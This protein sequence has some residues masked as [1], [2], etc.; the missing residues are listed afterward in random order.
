MTTGFSNITISMRGDDHE[1]LALTVHTGRIIDGEAILDSEQVAQ[2][3][4]LWTN[5]TGDFL[6][7]WTWGNTNDESDLVFA[8]TGPDGI[9]I[10]FWSTIGP[11]NDDDRYIGQRP[12]SNRYDTAS[13][14][15]YD[16]LVITILEGPAA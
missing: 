13:A 6:T 7:T 9:E 10:T 16:D 5:R 12:L 3:A 14:P 11:D 15:F 8:E 4:D 2:V 1:P